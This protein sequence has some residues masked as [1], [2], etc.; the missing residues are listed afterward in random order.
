MA[1]KLLDL[2]RETAWLKRLS[3]RTK[4]TYVKYIER[5][6]LYHKIWYPLALG[7]NEAR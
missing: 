4:E 5:F 2:V 7:E 6:V 1:K 3:H